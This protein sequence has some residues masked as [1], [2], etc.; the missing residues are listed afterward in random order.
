M[1]LLV[2]AA[3]SI[4]AMGEITIRTGF[5]KH[6]VWVEVEDTGNG[7]PA[8]N[9]TRIFEP[10]FTT[11]PVG[12]GTGLGLSLSYG[13]IKKHH[14]RIDVISEVGKGTKFKVVIPQNVAELVVV[15]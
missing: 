13:I 7:I 1:N 8:E 11:K 12:K 15:A 5:D 9:L 14:G 2:N 6:D 3:H 4:Q 10:F